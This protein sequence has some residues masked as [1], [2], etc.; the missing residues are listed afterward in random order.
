MLQTPS[1]HGVD[2]P[3][4][5]LADMHEPTVGLADVLRLLPQ[6]CEPDDMLCVALVSRECRSALSSTPTHFWSLWMSWVC[7]T[8]V[9]LPEPRS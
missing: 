6:L 5:G 2:E 1:V 8:N 9:P 7:S 4:A 3:A